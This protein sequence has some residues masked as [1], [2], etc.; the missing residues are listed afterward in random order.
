MRWS[1]SQCVIYR[2]TH[3][4]LAICR[5]WNWNFDS[6][7]VVGAH[8][9]V[10]RIVFDCNSDLVWMSI[11]RANRAIPRHRWRM[12]RLF[13]WSH[14]IA[15]CLLRSYSTLKMCSDPYDQATAD[16]SHCAHLLSLVDLPSTTSHSTWISALQPFIRSR[17]RYQFLCYSVAHD[18]VFGPSHDLNSFGF[19]WISIE[20][21]FLSP[22]PFRK[23]QLNTC[24]ITF[25]LNF[26]LFG[27]CLCSMCARARVH[28]VNS[29]WI[30]FYW[31]PFI[32]LALMSACV[33]ILQRQT[34]IL[35]TAA[36]QWTR[37]KRKSRPVSCSY[38]I[39][40]IIITLQ[41]QIIAYHIARKL[42]T[43]YSFHRVHLP[44]RHNKNRIL[45][46]RSESDFLLFPF[47]RGR[48]LLSNG[49]SGGATTTAHIPYSVS[50][51]MW[52]E[53]N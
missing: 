22:F 10:S 18:S 31:V 37:T 8:F 40:E 16:T 17:I 1:L 53:W 47:L 27:C 2:F 46:W 7:N 51:D 26:F 25:S 48:F 38:A 36:M 32:I 21:Q 4:Q 12:M 6:P 44:R 9:T 28:L 45:H 41:R 20:W 11:G 33:L 43:A 49:A 14:V 23:Q 13:T 35:C 29:C 42:L 39:H 30:A 15:A 50:N 5:R 52:F 24:K 19:S 34:A 3:T